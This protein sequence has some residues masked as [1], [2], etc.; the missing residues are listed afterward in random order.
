MEYKKYSTVYTVPLFDT[1]ELKGAE[2]LEDEEYEP[3][4]LAKLYVNNIFQRSLAHLYGF[5]EGK[6]RRVAVDSNGNLLVKGAEKA[7]EKYDVITV[8]SGD[9]ESVAQL[10]SFPEG[11]TTTRTVD[12]YVKVNPVLIRFIP[13]DDTVLE[14]IELPANSFYSVDV[15]IKGFKVQNAVAGSNAVVQVIGWF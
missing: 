5:Y 11:I 9:T 4:Y 12:V 3:A 1:Q 14:Q 10:F 7:I 8:T 2:N 15:A 13:Y 6:W